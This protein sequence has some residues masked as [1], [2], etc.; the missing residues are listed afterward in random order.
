MLLAVE[1]VAGLKLK[2]SYPL[3]PVP[4]SLA[5]ATVT[6]TKTDKSTLRHNLELASELVTYIP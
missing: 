5:T 6:S 1:H 3:D 2:L 4:W